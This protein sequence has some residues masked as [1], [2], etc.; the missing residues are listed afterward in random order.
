MLKKQSSKNIPIGSLYAKDGALFI[1]EEIENTYSRS[2]SKLQQ[3]AENRP[4]RQ[5][6]IKNNNTVFEPYE[7]TAVAFDLN[8]S[9]DISNDALLEYLSFGGNVNNL[10]LES[11]IDVAT[12]MKI[13]NTPQYHN[14][15]TNNYLATHQNLFLSDKLIEKLTLREKIRLYTENKYRTKELMEEH[16]EAFLLVVRE[17][18]DNFISEQ[19]DLVSE[20]PSDIRV[21]IL[22]TCHDFFADDNFIKPE[23]DRVIKILEEE[24]KSLSLRAETID[25]MID[26]V[27]KYKIT[28]DDWQTKKDMAT[29]IVHTLKDEN[30]A[31]L[32]EINSK[33]KTIR[34]FPI[35]DSLSTSIL[36]SKSW[37]AFSIK[38]KKGDVIMTTIISSVIAL[39]MCITSMFVGYADATNTLPLDTNTIITNTDDYTLADESM[40]I[41]NYENIGFNS[42]RKP[43]TPMI[44]DLPIH[45]RKPKIDIIIHPRLIRKPGI[46]L[47]IPRPPIFPRYPMLP[48]KSEIPNEQMLIFPAIENTLEMIAIN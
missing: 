14:E 27:V 23:K 22:K 9:S 11:V 48:R 42:G 32:S 30:K 18:L 36:H 7:L 34:T 41:E 6:V 8:Q 26:A 44:K 35:W 40:Q 33:I 21:N 17:I 47:P 15:F 13:M 45:I 31:K 20:N 37:S 46:V 38:F 16:K 39:T 28:G 29:N 3:T 4:D 5:L 12:M 24:K 2:F 10:I 1:I 25:I 43:D 19:E